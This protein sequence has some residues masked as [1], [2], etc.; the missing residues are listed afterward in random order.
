M[1][2]KDITGER[3]GKLVA[4]ELVDLPSEG[5]RP[6]LRLWRCS[7]DCGR[8]VELPGAR[9]R[10]GGA[11]SCGCSHLESKH[12][13]DLVGQR[14]GNL[15]VVEEAGRDKD[16]GVLWRCRCDCGSETLV[17]SGRLNR[18]MT[19]SC[20]CLRYAG[21][22]GTVEDADL[23]GRRF[24]RLVVEEVVKEPGRTRTWRCRCDCGEIKLVMTSMLKSG[25]VQSCG[26]LRKSPHFQDHVGERFGRLAIESF[27]RV[28]PGGNT[29]WAC[30]CDCGKTTEATISNLKL[31]RVQ[32]C[33]CLVS[34]PKNRAPREDLVGQVFGR[35]TVV[36]R[37]Y[38][39]NPGE[40]GSWRCRCSC[41]NETLVSMSKL[42]D[43]STAS[44]G[45]LATEYR[46]SLKKG[47][48][49]V[50]TEGY[51]DLYH[52]VHPNAHQ[53]G[54]VAEHVLIMSQ[55]I[56]RPLFP[57]E[58]VHH[59]N[60][61]KQDNRIENLELHSGMHGKGAAVEDLIAHAHA[62]LA[63]YKPEA[64]VGTE[65]QDPVESTGGAM[66]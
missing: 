18:G 39:K 57:G 61:D 27:I 16:R 19:K 45:C 22:N 2:I 6:R 42:R 34:E 20:G 40:R 65:V 41:G 14:F 24:G 23:T 1:H 11:K 12:K 63:R 46:R 4:L 60:G 21:R 58:T 8:T 48:R 66:Q 59:K 55:R 25:N 13:S 36:E 51:V 44:C 37:V 28:D 54:Y 15:V 30:R 35:L 32:S 64:L 50:N 52:P 49:R 26:C 31:G 17:S 56:G 33:G 62:V 53:N 38:P 47:G 29:R 5:P 43:G 10:S 9:L 3:F 7:C